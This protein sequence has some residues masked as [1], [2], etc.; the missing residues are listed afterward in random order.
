MN[1]KTLV[2]LSLLVG[3]GAAL[4]LIIPGFFLGMKPDLMLIMMFLGIFLFTEK[5]NV[6]LLA[7]LTGIISGLTS[8]FPGGLLPNIIDKFVTAFVIYFIYVAVKKSSS[9]YAVCALTGAGTLIS[10]AVFLG[11]ALL[12]S[13]LP[14]SAGFL[15][16]YSV[17]VLPAAV[18]NLAAMAIIYPMVSKI[19]KRTSLQPAIKN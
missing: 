14:G 13:G 1:T 6:L 4:H 16:L 12:I 9:V 11:S 5:K 18:F 2:S 17:V 15:G 10:G 19:L 8:T 3:I 7:L